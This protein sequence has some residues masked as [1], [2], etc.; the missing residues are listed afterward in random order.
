M[1]KL[2]G[3]EEEIIEGR[4]GTW[5]RKRRVNDDNGGDIF[6]VCKRGHSAMALSLCS[7]QPYCIIL[8]LLRLNIFTE[9]SI[10]L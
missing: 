6:G 2:N 4:D 10:S 1:C 8:T 9:F 3:K 7:S 5:K